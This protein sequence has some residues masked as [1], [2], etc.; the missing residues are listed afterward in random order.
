MSDTS[1]PNPSQNQ[2]PPQY[3]P[4]PAYQPPPQYPPAGYP[5]PV[6][7]VQP[8][9]DSDQRMWAMLGHLGGILI[10]FIAPLIVMLVYG[11]RSPFVRRHA[12]EALNFQITVAI[13]FAAA[14]VLMFVLIGFLLLP[15]VWI[16]SIVFSI[17]GGLAANRGEEYRYPVSIRLVK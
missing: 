3:Q 2:P 11:E 7:G 16:G 14:F 4:P 12:V 1:P 17:V 6:A 15:V 8:L 9:T 5:Q 13:G 10:G